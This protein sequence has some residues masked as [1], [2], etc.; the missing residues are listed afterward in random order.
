MSQRRRLLSNRHNRYS[1][2]RR[3]AALERLPGLYF[4]NLSFDRSPSSSLYPNGVRLSILSSDKNCPLSESWTRL[5]FGLRFFPILNH[6]LV[7]ENNFLGETYKP[8]FLTTRWKS[9][10]DQGLNVPFQ[11]F[12]YRVEFKEACD[13]VWERILPAATDFVP[14]LCGKLVSEVDV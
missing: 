2:K 13:Q 12:V 4:Q 5:D 8:E 6:I 7:L 1:T 11:C 14:L 9:R 3:L 10:F